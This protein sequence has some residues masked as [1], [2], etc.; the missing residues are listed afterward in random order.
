[1]LALQAAESEVVK[2][3]ELIRLR[4]CNE[5]FIADPALLLEG[6]VGANETPEMNVLGLMTCRSLH[7]Q[8]CSGGGRGR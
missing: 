8:P 2:L 3:K 7:E 6:K 5:E 4:G 1:M